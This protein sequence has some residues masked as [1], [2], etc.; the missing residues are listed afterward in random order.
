MS[1]L[2]S[3]A[4]RNPAPCAAMTLGA[5][6]RVL[7]LT[8][9]SL[10]SDEAVTLAVARAPISQVMTLV[11]SLEFTPPLHFALM[12]FWLPL[13]SDPLRGLRLFS[14]LC[15]IA[16]LP[17]FWSFCRRLFAVSAPLA[18]FLAA[19]SSLWI[20]AAQ[21]GR[22]YALLILLGV[23]QADLVWRLREKWSARFAVLY[24]AAAFCGMLT[25]HYYH[26]LVLSLGLSLLFE[27]K[28]RKRSWK[29]WVILHAAV[30]LC[31][32]PWT[33][34]LLDRS[35]LPVS[36]WVLSAPFS[37]GLI[38]QTFG[39]FLIDAAYLGLTITGWTQALGWAAL[40][41]TAA[42]LWNLDKKGAGDE[43]AAVRF[44]LVNLAVPL[45]AAGVLEAV[46]GRPIVQPRYLAC[47]TVF[48]Y[49]LLAQ[50]AWRLGRAARLA[51]AA[52]A[53]CGVCAYFT[54]NLVIDPRLAELSVFI[55]R[56]SDK[57]MPI[58]HWGALEYVALRYY[59]LPERA[60]FL[61]QT[62]PSDARYSHLTGYEA[63]IAP[64]N[65]AALPTVVVIDPYRHA[66]VQRVGLSSGAQLL[67]LTG[68]LR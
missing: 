58:V 47:L 28:F 54:S 2:A 68:T 52:V 21:T 59:Y 49:P 23:I 22:C 55:Q 25:H 45:A 39:T 60:N 34:A 37:P 64:K 5:L 3:W 31:F 48:F 17:L 4:R 67:E 50:A 24:G 56:S 8:R 57:R 53:V 11:G 61:L 16:A 7:W 18:F 42:G 20:H 13:W 33:P 46:V 15:G 62:D 44:C 26:F 32:L 51:A 30:W 12:H 65:L 19:F 29:P 36:S 10:W 27:P 43:K 41:L 38:A 63:L 35:H 1:R 40:A 14:A 9:A 6:L 66:F